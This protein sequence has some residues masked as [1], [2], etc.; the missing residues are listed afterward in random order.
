[1]V[2]RKSYVGYSNNIEVKSIRK[3]A[4]GRTKLP[5]SGLVILEPWSFTFLAERGQR[6]VTL[7]DS[8]VSL[9]ETRQGESWR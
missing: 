6:R 2:V 3:V 5:W 4:G 8:E 9:M 1:M 7:E